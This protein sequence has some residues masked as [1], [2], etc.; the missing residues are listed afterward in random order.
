MRPSDPEEPR[1]VSLFELWM[2]LTPEEWDALPES[3][4]DGGDPEG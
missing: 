2:G 3:R 4:D 1:D